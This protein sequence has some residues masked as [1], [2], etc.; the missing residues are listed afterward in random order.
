MHFPFR[1]TST[2]HIFGSLRFTFIS[3]TFRTGFF[4]GFFFGW[5]FSPGFVATTFSFHPFL[6]GY[7]T[8]GLVGSAFL[9]SFLAGT[10]RFLLHFRFSLPFRQF[11]VL[12]H[13]G[14]T[15]FHS[16]IFYLSTFLAHRFSHRTGLI[17]PSFPNTRSWIFI[18][19]SFIAIGCCSFHFLSLA[20][21][22]LATFHSHHFVS[23]V[24]RARLIFTYT[25]HATTDSSLDSFTGHS[26]WTLSSCIC[27]GLGLCVLFHYLFH[28]GHKF[29]YSSHFFLVLP[30]FHI[31]IYSPFFSFVAHSPPFLCISRCLTLLHGP[32]RTICHIWTRHF[33]RTSFLFTF[34]SSPS[35]HSL[36]GLAQRSWHRTAFP[37]TILSPCIWAC[38]ALSL[39]PPSSG[40]PFH[41]Y[42]F[43]HAHAAFAPHFRFCGTRH[44]LTVLVCCCGLYTA[45]FG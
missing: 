6:F 38:T 13:T 11:H 15:V 32:S 7:R 21:F 19:H 41:R 14:H 8:F 9:I 10:S 23:T 5:T 22:L 43:L 16:H 28:V 26:S 2:V 44:G 24:H 12:R 30:P 39:S 35:L 37:F 17:L 31:S 25:T 3:W 42:C 34:G 40:S 4:H 45:G 20:L 33:C 29:C 18:S 1:A 27:I 36:A